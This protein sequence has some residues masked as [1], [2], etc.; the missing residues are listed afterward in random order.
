MHTLHLLVILG[1]IAYQTS[2][3]PGKNITVEIELSKS[4]GQKSKSGRSICIKNLEACGNPNE[5]DKCC[6]GLICL[7]GHSGVAPR[8]VKSNA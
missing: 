1:L 7:G 6:A 3:Q 2:A 4:F 8:C 5:K